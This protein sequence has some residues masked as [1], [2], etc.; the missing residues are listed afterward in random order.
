MQKQ[1]NG[2]MQKIK[3]GFGELIEGAKQDIKRLTQP[4]PE[5]SLGG[6]D[7]R[8]GDRAAKTIDTLADLEPQ[9]NM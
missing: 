4:A 3:E 2:K 1:I 9:A 8:W 6:E 7:G 5:I